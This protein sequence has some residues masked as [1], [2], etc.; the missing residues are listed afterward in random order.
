MENKSVFIKENLQPIFEKFKDM[1]KVETVVGEAIQIG[2]AT[3]VPFVD[4]TMGFGTG[5]A[6]KGDCGG[7]KMEATA[8]LVIKGERVE[9][10]NIKGSAKYSGFD[11]LIGMVPEII[12]KLKKDQYIYINE[13][14]EK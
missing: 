7:A 14:D 10:F 9:L 5:G 13:N 1:I 11:R 12:S 4:V 2:D 3:L 8:I 6:G